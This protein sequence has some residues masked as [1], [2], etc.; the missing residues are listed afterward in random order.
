MRFAVG[1]DAVRQWYT[2]LTASYARREARA[3]GYVGVGQCYEP[4]SMGGLQWSVG[5]KSR[6]AWPRRARVVPS[7]RLLHAL[8]WIEPGVAAI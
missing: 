1:G 7:L 3:G 5:R 4:T 6:Q 2:A 8:R